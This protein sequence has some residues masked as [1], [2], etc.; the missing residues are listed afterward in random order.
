M[1][2][3]KRLELRRE[4]TKFLKFGYLVDFIALDAL[5]KIYNNSITA[6]RD[7]FIKILNY[8]D[9]CIVTDMAAFGMNRDEPLFMVNLDF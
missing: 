4:C 2:Y 3:D 9:D 6:L 5:L 7:K 1:T 8:E